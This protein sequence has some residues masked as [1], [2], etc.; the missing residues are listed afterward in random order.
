[1]ASAKPCTTETTNNFNIS[2]D[3]GIHAFC[4]DNCVTHRQT[5][6]HTRAYAHMNARASLLA[7][8][9]FHETCECSV[10]VRPAKS[11][12]CTTRNVRVHKTFVLFARYRL[13]GLN[14]CVKRWHVYRP[15]W[16]AMYKFQGYFHIQFHL[17]FA[18]L[19]SFRFPGF[20]VCCF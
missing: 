9:R 14:F 17:K 13:N 3:M 20:A 2:Y 16:S 8:R 6:A 18:V 12:S 10:L 11:N 4:M 19:R 5:H 7:P 15:L 1:M